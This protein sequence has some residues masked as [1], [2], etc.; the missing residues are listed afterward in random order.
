MIAKR[1]ERAEGFEELVAGEK[2]EFILT[3]DEAVPPLNFKMAIQIAPTSRKRSVKEGHRQKLQIPLR[4]FLDRSCS[5]L[6][7][8]GEVNLA[9]IR[10]QKTRK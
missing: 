4:S 2:A 5:P 10:F 1:R 7:F 9:S 8:L 3:L 6:T